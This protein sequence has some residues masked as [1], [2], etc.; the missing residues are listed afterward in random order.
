[1]TPD[2]YETLGV[3]RTAD[4]ATIRRAYRRKA[5]AAHPDGGG[6]QDKFGAL[7]KAHDVL[8]DDERRAKYDAT[9]DIDEKTIDN[10]QGE[11]LQLVCMILDG[12]IN[13][14]AQNGVS[15]LQH[16]LAEEM[17]ARCRREIEEVEKQRAQ[18][19]A[20][21]KNAEKLLGRFKLKKG[22]KTTNNAIE[23]ILIGRVR[24]FDAHIRLLDEKKA[25]F[26]G[27]LAIIKDYDFTVDARE[28]QT[29][30]FQAFNLFTTTST[31]S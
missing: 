13:A 30:R 17:A 12:A 22:A 28:P 10:T 18:M 8:T 25:K 7:T 15:P 9:G 27:A 23:A 31:N 20:T 24:S 21:Q 29:I 3:D 2:L 14:L 6:S 4:K 26:D 5:K 19:V 11:I 16:P 1:M